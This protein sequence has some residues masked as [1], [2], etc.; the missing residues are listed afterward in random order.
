MVH[1]KFLYTCVYLSVLLQ[2]S[3]FYLYI[4]MTQE[5]QE[6]IYIQYMYIHVNDRQNINEICKRPVFYNNL[7]NL[8][9]NVHI[10]GLELRLW[11]LMPLSTK[12]QLYH[13]SQLYWWRKPEDTEKTTDLPQVTDRLDH[14]MLYHLVVS[15]I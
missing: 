2:D 1:I 5:L 9:T 6:E 11:C 7:S 12:F 14:I 10:L 4:L 13:D 8:L 15:G 3:R